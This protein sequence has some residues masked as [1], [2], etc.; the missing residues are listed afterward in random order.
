[1]KTLSDPLPHPSTV[2][3]SIATNAVVDNA[4]FGQALLE[5]MHMSCRRVGSP[6]PWQLHEVAEDKVA[7]PM[8]VVDH[9]LDKLLQDALARKSAPQS[10][11]TATENTL[12]SHLVAESD[13]MFHA[14]GC[15]WVFFSRHHTRSEDD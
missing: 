13:G 12:L 11:V 6:I 1:M 10:S 4:S 15:L 7:K 9:F 3:D 2:R 14:S 8:K 5:A